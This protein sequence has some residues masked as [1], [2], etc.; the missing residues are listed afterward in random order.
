MA[1]EIIMGV[2]AADEFYYGYQHGFL[3]GEDRIRQLVRTCAEAGINSICWRV[4]CLGQVTYRSKVRTII[5]TTVETPG[6]FREASVDRLVIEQCDPPAVVIDEAAKCGLKVYLYVTLFD[7]YYPGCESEFEVRH[8]QFTWQHRLLDHRIRGLLSYSHP[9]VREHRLAELKELMAYGP[10]GIYLDTARTHSGIQ[11]VCPL[12]LTGK[13][14]YLQYGFN[15]PECQEYQRRFGF[16]P[17]LGNPA[18]AAVGDFDPG[19][20]NRLRGEYLTQFL[21][22]AR[23]EARRTGVELIAGFYTDAECYLS[24]AGRRGRVP[25]GEF[26]HDWQTWIAEDLVDG[27]VILSEHRRYGA[28]DWR[29]HSAAQF[30]DARQRGKHVAISGATEERIDG[31]EDPPAPLPI[32]ANQDRKLFIQALD[33]ALGACLA[34]DADGLF[35]YESASVEEHDYWDDL[36]RILRANR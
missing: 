24:P 12:P 19:K 21:R 9:E 29:E 23:A 7:E 16:N 5:G 30:A 8:P 22:E 20:W 6:R 26:H 4:S 27:F 34:T 25:L 31:M 17:R 14:P 33:R 15:E 2:D 35:L 32:A 10:D 11:H 18:D 13:D 3:Y 1:K 28:K 36:A